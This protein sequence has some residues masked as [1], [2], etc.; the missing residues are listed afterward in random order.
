MNRDTVKDVQMK[1]MGLPESLVLFG[2]P[3]VLFYVIT[4]VL[5]PYFNKTYAIHPVLTWFIFGG[6]LLFIPLFVL[7]IMLFRKDGYDFDLKTMAVRF[8]LVRFARTDWLWLLGAVVAIM[9]LNGVIMAVWK[10]LS[11]RFCISP[12][13]TSAPFLHFDPL[14]GSARLLLFIWIPFFFFNIVGEELLWRGYILPRQELNFG[15]FA[16]L[17]NAGLWLIFHICFGLDLIIILL[18]VLFIVPYVVQR[19]KNTWI[20]IAVHALVNGPS[21]ILISLGLI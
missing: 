11:V 8:R 10:L 1:P 15:K 5:I 9:V 16:W 20:G 3:A 7:A 19:R 2:I 4:R 12:M 18:P 6:L 14:R 13:D 17:V 21:F